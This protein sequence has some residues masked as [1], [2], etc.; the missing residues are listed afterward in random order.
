MRQASPKGVAEENSMRKSNRYPQVLK[1]F[2]DYLKA[3]SRIKM[4]DSNEAWGT[5]DEEQFRERIR[6]RALIAF[7]NQLLYQINPTQRR[8]I[9]RYHIERKR[10]LDI[11]ADLN[12]AY[13]WC[14]AMKNEALFEL[15]QT[16]TSPDFEAALS[17]SILDRYKKL[18]A[19]GV[20]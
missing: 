7:I 15:E 1:L 13:E 12:I 18:Q 17:Q 10:L 14:S 11:A 6:L 20:E 3:K 19:G 9:Y 4:I 2:G 8:I 5:M 16:I